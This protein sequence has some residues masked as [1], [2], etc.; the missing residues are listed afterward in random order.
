[1]W[2]PASP[3]YDTLISKVSNRNKLEDILSFLHL[4]DEDTEKKMKAEGDRLAVRHW[5]TIF[6]SV[7]VRIYTKQIVKSVWTKEWFDQKSSF[8]F[9]ST[10]VT[11]QQSGDSND[12]AYVMLIMGTYHASLC[13]MERTESYEVQMA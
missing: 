10:Y 1:M 13:T 5:M 9:V 6:K 7:V 12:G 2:K 3:W 8:L 4:V 11:N